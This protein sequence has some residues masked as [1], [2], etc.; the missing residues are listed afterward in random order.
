MYEVRPEFDWAEPEEED[1]HDDVDREGRRRRDEGKI[2]AHETILLAWVGGEMGM[3]ERGTGRSHDG[4]GMGMGMGSGAR[5]MK[6]RPGGR[7]DQ[8]PDMGEREAQ[9]GD[10]GNAFAETDFDMGGFGGGWRV[11]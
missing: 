4:R 9:Q 5:N 8:Y 3:F 10:S 1:G 7:A 6:R 11:Q 2:L